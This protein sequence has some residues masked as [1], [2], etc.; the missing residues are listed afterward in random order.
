MNNILVNEIKII[1]II[2]YNYKKSNNYL[3][4]NYFRVVVFINLYQIYNI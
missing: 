4:I 3:I 2:K 1:I